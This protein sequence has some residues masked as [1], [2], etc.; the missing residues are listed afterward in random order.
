MDMA[1]HPQELTR[2]MW[3]N[4]A[5]SY[6]AITL[7]LVLSLFMSLTWLPFAALFEVYV[8]ATLR[9]SDILSAVSSC[10]VMTGIAIRPG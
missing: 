9:K 6:G 2:T 3:R 5:V 7:P 10:S 1:N 4:W 8:L